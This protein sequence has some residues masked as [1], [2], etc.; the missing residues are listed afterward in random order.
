MVVGKK[1]FFSS[2]LP[3]LSLITPPPLDQQAAAPIKTKAAKPAKAPKAPKV[4]QKKG[5]KGGEA[6]EA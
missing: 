3:S 6:G 1:N 4:H 5:G 2:P